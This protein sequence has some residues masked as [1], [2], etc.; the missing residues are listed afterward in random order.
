MK[1]VSL[2]TRPTRHTPR[3]V[4]TRQ[5]QHCFPPQAHMLAPAG[6]ALSA[7][8]PSLASTV[9]TGTAN[10]CTRLRARSKLSYLRPFLLAASCFPPQAHMLAPAGLALSAQSPSV[11]STVSTGTVNPCTRLRA[12]SKLSYLRPSLLAASRPLEHGAQSGPGC[13]TCMEAA[14]VQNLFTQAVLSKT[15]SNTL[16]VMRQEGDLMLHAQ[17]IG[18]PAM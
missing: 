5:G 14:C 17:Q 18:Y 4:P 16:Q 9:S 15:S 3:V 1:P 7:Q 8:S 12:R 11:A 2:T 6:L 13:V 10:P